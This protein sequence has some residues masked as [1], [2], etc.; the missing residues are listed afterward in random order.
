M[1]A[2]DVNSGVFLAFPDP[3][4]E[5]YDNTAY[6]GVNFG[7]EIQIDE[8][9]RPDNAPHRRGLWIQGTGRGATDAFGRRVER[10]RNHRQW[11]GSHGRAQW[12][13]DK[14]IPFYR[15]PAIAAP[16][17]AR[18][19]DPHRSALLPPYP[20]ARVVTPWP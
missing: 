11:A 20:V 10:L 18:T 6:G 9:A 2:P 8:L 1:T 13:S 15:R 3:T 16:R 7:F 4:K 12:T 19:A 14:S 17:P 5:G